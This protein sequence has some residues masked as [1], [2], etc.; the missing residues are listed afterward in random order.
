MSS[1]VKMRPETHLIEMADVFV[2]L[3][4]GLAEDAAVLTQV[5]SE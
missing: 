4:H 2:D 5:Q 3:Q 1:V